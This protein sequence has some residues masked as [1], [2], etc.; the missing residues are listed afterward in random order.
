MGQAAGAL[1]QALSDGLAIEQLDYSNSSG[2]LA[3]QVVV[4]D[5]PSLEQLRQR[6]SETG[7]KVQ[8]GSAS[9]EDDGIKARVLLGGTL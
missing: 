7:L 1:D 4:S 6:L 9:R 3:L 8:V 2:D 5:F